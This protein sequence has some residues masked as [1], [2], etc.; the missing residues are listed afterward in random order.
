[1]PFCLH[2]LRAIHTCTHTDSGRDVLTEEKLSHSLGTWS[3]WR[4]AGLRRSV[5][6][7]T[8]DGE[9]S[10]KVKRLPRVLGVGAVS[11]AFPGG[12]WA[13]AVTDSSEGGT[14]LPALSRS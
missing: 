4:L 10:S 3:W 9:F 5:P 14:V 8:A 1:M 11:A 13:S 7:G 6:A 2:H 12:C